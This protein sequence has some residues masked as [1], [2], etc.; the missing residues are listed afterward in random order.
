M[1]FLATDTGFYE[2]LFFTL[3]IADN[4]QKLPK[5][6]EKHTTERFF[7][8]PKFEDTETHTAACT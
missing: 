7:W 1:S 2:Y 4:V 5:T 6:K 8:Q 3:N